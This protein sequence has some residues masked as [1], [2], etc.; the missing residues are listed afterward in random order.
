MS[1]NNVSIILPCYNVEDYIDRCIKS[2]LDQSYSKFE[3]IIINDGSTDSTA[4]K[5]KYW[6][7]TDDRIRVIKTENKGQ[8]NARNIGIKESKGDYITFVDSDDW[9]SKDYLRNL[10]NGI[11]SGASI[12][13]SNR[14]IVKNINKLSDEIITNTLGTKKITHMDTLNAF[15]KVLYQ[16]PDCEVWGKMFPKDF[17]RDISFPINTYYE[18][19][20]IT[21]ELLAKAKKIAYIDSYDYFYVQRADSSINSCFN[22]KKID[23]LSQGK[24]LSELVLKLYPQLEKALASK[25][26]SAYSNVWMQIP[27]ELKYKDISN[28]LWNEIKEKSKVTKYLVPRNKKVWAASVISLLGPNIYKQMY[29][30]GVNRNE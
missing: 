26:I 3:L 21:F 7:V 5:I 27:D 1:D 24:K 12:A 19:M 14:N 25:L 30:V 22:Y 9:V 10:I 29:M 20:V 13:I 4:N 16:K 28:V 15:E 6:E 11:L 8:G 23:I 18:D 2:I 17:F